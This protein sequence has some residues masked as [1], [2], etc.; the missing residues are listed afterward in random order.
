MPSCSSGSK[1]AHTEFFNNKKKKIGIE[2]EDKHNNNMNCM[3]S[4]L[5]TGFTG[6]CSCEAL[7]QLTGVTD[8]AI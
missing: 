8:N 6:H 2:E 4:G 1:S 7:G 5:R 3:A